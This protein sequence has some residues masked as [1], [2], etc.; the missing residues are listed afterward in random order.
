MI[1]KE[2]ISID[3]LQLNIGQIEGLP[4]NPRVMK[5]AKYKK[6]LDSLKE[7]PELLEAKPIIVIEYRN[8]YVVIAG[9]YRTTGCKELYKQGMSIFAEIPCAILPDDTPIEKLRAYATK[10]NTHYGEFDFDMLANDWDSIELDKWGV[11]GIDFPVIE[12]EDEAQP[13]KEKAAKTC[14]HCG[15]EL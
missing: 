10:D 2:K 3:S 7:D 5:D 4:A 12:E 1:R 6:L 11:D 15:A 8:K 13:P 14:P 9:N